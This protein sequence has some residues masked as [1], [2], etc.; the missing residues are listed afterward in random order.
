MYKTPDGRYLAEMK[1][2]VG[3]CPIFGAVNPITD[4]NYFTRL[5][6]SANWIP[7]QY[8]MG[9]E[10]W[11][12]WFIND[13]LPNKWVQIDEQFSFDPKTLKVVELVETKTMRLSKSNP[14]KKK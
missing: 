2:M 5:E 4:G 13:A 3:E 7:L 8:T 9:M 12:N 14:K 1:P 6:V 11:L 10:G